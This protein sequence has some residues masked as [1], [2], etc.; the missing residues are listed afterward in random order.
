M[1]KVLLAFAALV[2][3]SLS[4]SLALANEGWY[5]GASTGST[6]QKDACDGVVGS[7]DDT[8]TGWKIVGG[9]QVNENWGFEFG[10]VDLGESTLLGTF[11]GF[12]ISAKAEAD[13]F[14]FAGVG[15]A[16]LGE[17][18]AFFGKFG[19]LRWDVDVSGTVLGLTASESDDGI[20]PMFGVGL[21]Y[22]VTERVAI[23]GEWERFLDV[24][25]NNTT[26]ESDVDLLSIGVQVGF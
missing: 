2:L 25:D 24:G 16:P 6:D 8:D 3:T 22:D 14:T 12:P 20:D 13:G 15:T 17:K 7:C 9:R 19:L 26:G 1:R 11:L 4:A 10:F 5:V 23:R 21:K 18:G